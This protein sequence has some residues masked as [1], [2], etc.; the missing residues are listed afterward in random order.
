MTTFR[1]HTASGTVDITAKTP[2]EA[3]KIFAAGWPGAIINK[4]KRVKE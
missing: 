2:D 1:I 4:I 3:R